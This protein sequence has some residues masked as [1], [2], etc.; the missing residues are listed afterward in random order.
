MTVVE[1]PNRQIV[2]SISSLVN[3]GL[4][5][6]AYTRSIEIPLYGAIPQQQGDGFTAEIFVNGQTIGTGPV[7][8]EG[9]FKKD[10]ILLKF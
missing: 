1:Q 5:R 4:D 10:R 2:F 6:N 8:S 9:S 7:N 3:V